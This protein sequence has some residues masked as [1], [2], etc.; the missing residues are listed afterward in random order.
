MEKENKKI[1][2]Y[3]LLV[4][5]FIAAIG[6]LGYYFGFLGAIYNV[7]MPQ[8]FSKFNICLLYTSPSPRD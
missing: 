8:T 3:A 6:F 5:I 4:I 1:F 2:A 7:M